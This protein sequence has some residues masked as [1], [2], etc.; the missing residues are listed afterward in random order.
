[1]EH[2]AEERQLPMF[3]PAEEE[4]EDDNKVSKSVAG[5]SWSQIKQDIGL[6]TLESVTKIDLAKHIE[7]K[8]IGT[9]ISTNGESLELFSPAK[10]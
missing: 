10:S 2:F 9:P 1:L 4:D 7:P 8:K 3:Q 6:P 5:H